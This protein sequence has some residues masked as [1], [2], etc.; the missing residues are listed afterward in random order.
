MREPLLSA[1]LATDSSAT[2]R[3]VVE[4][5]RK[6]TIRDRIELILIAP[7][8]AAVEAVLQ[9]TGEFAAIRILENP[10]TSLPNARTAGIRA[11]TA[12]T[13]FV[14]ETHSYPHPGFAEAL[15]ERM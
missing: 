14:G 7:S 1:I 5:F 8:A 11:A 6:Q 10:V 13:V 15:V 3:P 9:H 4:R 12:A 2:I